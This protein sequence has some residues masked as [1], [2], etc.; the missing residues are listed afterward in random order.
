MPSRSRRS[1]VVVATVALALTGTL[2]STASAAS[3]VY[4]NQA[5]LQ[6]AVQ[7]SAFPFADYNDPH[8]PNIL[9]EARILTAHWSGWGAAT[10]TAQ[11]EA[12]IQWVDTT[13][14]PHNL[15]EATLPV[16]ITA[17]GL[18][19]CGGVSLYTSL[20]MSLAPGTTVPPHFS[21]VDHDEHVGPCRVHAGAYV[22]G[23]EERT[24]PNGCF[25]KGLRELVIRSP[26]SL[27]YCAM[28][29]KG[30]GHGT[31]TGLGVARIGFRQYGLRVKLSR[32]RWCKRWT[33]SYTQETAEVWGNGETL[34]GQ[35]NVSNSA[36]ARL[37][38]LVGR[39]GQPH[40]T[41]H[42]AMPSEAAC[43]R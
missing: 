8:N 29:W 5:G 4:V 30:W 22:A 11:S 6:T 23:Q 10:A 40:K 31:T 36:A 7:P 39:A 17:S 13:T 1:L 21:Q 35:G 32:I 38:G 12:H 3:P 43:S 37:R 19:T 2:A 33:V 41:V 16:V 42:L 28:R 18:K 20:S 25:F 14:G 24:D 34:T 27:S 9:A 15:Q 26:F